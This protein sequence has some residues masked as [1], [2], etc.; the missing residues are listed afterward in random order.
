VYFVPDSRGET[1]SLA[2]R[3]RAA[4]LVCPPGSVVCGIT[5]LGLAS[6]QMPE[7]M[8]SAPRGPVHVLVPPGTQNRPRRDGLVIHQDRTM[9]PT[10]YSDRYRIAAARPEYCWTQVASRLLES[11]VPSFQPESDPAMRGNLLHGRKLALLQAV[12]LGDA[13][14]RRERPLTDPNRF[15]AQVARLAGT[16]HIP[17]VRDA[18]GLVRPGTDSPNETWLRLVVVDAGFPE[19]AV[20]HEFRLSN[21]GGFIDLSWPERLIA[22]EYQGGQ[23]FSDSS[24][25]RDDLERR[26]QLQAAG[27]VIVEAV[28]RDLH[29]P[30]DLIGR[31]TAAFSGR[32]P[33]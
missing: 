7:G 25:S 17:A 16:R 18:F 33:A 29:H 5:V 24:R 28:Y 32:G 27:W 6:V 11:P 2:H 9:P 12:Q 21:R 14:M 23:H 13:L 31:L 19:P 8:A 15:A 30:G 4:L 22:L 26:G 3:A 10:F 20:N 1:P